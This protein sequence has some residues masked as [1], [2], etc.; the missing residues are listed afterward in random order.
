M[1]F[2]RHAAQFYFQNIIKPFVGRE[3]DPAAVKEATG[4]FRTFAG[5]LNE[6]RRGRTYVVGD[7]LTVADFALAA[8][9]PYAWDVQLPVS[10]FAEIVLWHGRLNELPAWREPYLQT[11]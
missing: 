5:I 9:L 4:S 6:H 8:T 10:G 7:R 11:P 1:H 3:S 2:S